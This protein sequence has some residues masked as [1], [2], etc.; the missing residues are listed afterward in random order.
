VSLRIAHLHPFDL[1]PRDAIRLQTWLASKVVA[2]GTLPRR[3]RLVAGLD[4]AVDRDQ[5]VHAA[6]VVC[7]A[8]DWHVVETVSASAPAPMPY[9]PGLLSFREAPI[10]LDA[11]SRLRARPDLL[12]VDGHGIAHP[13]GL[14][15]AAHLGLHVDV[16]VVGVGKSLLCGTHGRPGRTRGGTY[17][18]TLSS[19]VTSPTASRCRERKY[20]TVAAAVRAYSHLLTPAEPYPIDRLASTIRW[21]RR[22]VSSSNF[23]M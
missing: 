17:S 9:I 21:H 16:P 13:R 11:L 7:A 1:P 2:R 22:F 14:G 19:N 8:P 15:L 5:H 23:L 3:M 20:A 10:L 4:C 12:L 18:T 6:A